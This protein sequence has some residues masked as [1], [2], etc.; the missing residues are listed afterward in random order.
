MRIPLLN[1]L[2]GRIKDAA[3]DKAGSTA[4]DFSLVVLPFMML[5]MS[6][7]E[8][9]WFYFANSQTDAATIE[10]ARFIRTGQAQ[11]GGFDKD[12]F[13]QKVCPNLA[14]F[15]DCNSSLTVEVETFASFAA[16]AAD[17]SPV[18][19]SNDDT[20]EIGALAYDPGAD[21]SIVR[22]RV[23]LLYQTINPTIGVNVSDASNNMRRLY[24]T[25]I[26]RNEP[27]S[28]NNKSVS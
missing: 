10:A 25:S 28:K 26:F 21:N 27:Y 14:V 15:G 3:R 24:G 12:E 16:L 6:T 5:M 20:A 11:E 23:C 9:G 19:C 22:I 18:V 2:A 1:K 7:M 17:T 8:V 4:V 13:F